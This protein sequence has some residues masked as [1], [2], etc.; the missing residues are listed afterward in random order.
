MNENIALYINVIYIKTASWNTE[1]VIPPDF[2]LKF[3]SQKKC[4]RRCSQRYADLRMSV[5]ALL[6]STP[7]IPV[8]AGLPL[9]PPLHHPQQYPVILRS[10]EIL[11]QLPQGILVVVFFCNNSFF[12][13]ALSP[14]SVYNNSFHPPPPA[15]KNNTCHKNH[16]IKLHILSQQMHLWSI[17][18]ERW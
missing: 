2:C 15:K 9:P 1:Y 14:V 17:Y 12:C 11:P 8:Q 5:K 16:A 10:T 6:G 3:D 13:Y 7:K 4:R 18:I